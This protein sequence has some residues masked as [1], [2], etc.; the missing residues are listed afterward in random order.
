MG[1]DS[2]H[3]V[4]NTCDD[5]FGG[6]GAT[7][8]DALTTAILFEKEDVVKQILTFISEL[9]FT[10]VAGGSSVQLFEVVI[11]H[12]G[13]MISAHDL[14]NPSG[15]S[16]FSH[17]V[18]KD[19][20]LRE[21]LYKQMVSLGGALTCGFSTPSGIPRN[22]VDPTL[23]TTDSGHSN[24]VAG[25]GSN[26]LE[27]ARLSELTG[28]GMYVTLA[29]RAEQFLINPHPVDKMPWPGI[30]G[31]FVKVA[32]GTLMDMKAS[33]GSLADSFYE[34]LLKAYIYDS[35][36]YEPYLERWKV[37]VDSTIRYIA[38]HPYG[39]PEQT[40]LPYWEGTNLFNVMDSLSWFAGG[41]FILGGMVTGNQTVL[42]FGLSIADTGGAMYAMTTTGLG[43]EFVVWTDDCNTAFAEQYHLSPCN[44]SNSVQVSGP[45]FKL[46]PEVIES[47]YYAYRATGNPKYQDW[48]WSAFL[49]LERVCRTESGY[50]AISDVNAVDGGEKLDKMESFLFAELLKYLWLL[51]LPDKD[52]NFHVQD[53]RTGRRNTWVL[54]TEAHLFKVAGVPV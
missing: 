45:E 18:T 50:S 54:N 29:R 53:S 25:V 42:D 19:K 3:P 23:C 49:A 31:S 38:S 1:H 46:R 48:A 22:W 5:D 2:L 4:T 44:G 20:L 33:W 51:H 32:D 35:V 15:G 28:H 26:I 12:L 40:L 21:S 11:R 24:T 43:A 14:L 30:L 7:A 6:W 8:V 27:F 47:W 17:L 52:A 9:D 39:R 10:Q 36:V 41:N 37:A 34:Y 16:P 13:S